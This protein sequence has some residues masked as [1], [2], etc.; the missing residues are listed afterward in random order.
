MG[1]KQERKKDK[2]D[3]NYDTLVALTK[4]AIADN[5]GL[6]DNLQGDV[7]L[8]PASLEIPGMGD[9]SELPSD[10]DRSDGGEDLGDI[11]AS[12]GASTSQGARNIIDPDSD[13]ESDYK[14]GEVPL[15]INP[16]RVTVFYRPPA[17]QHAEKII[18]DTVEAVNKLLTYESV[19]TEGHG[20][21]FMLCVYPRMTNPVTPILENILPGHREHVQKAI[22]STDQPKPCIVDQPSIPIDRRS[23]LLEKNYCVKY[24]DQKNPKVYKIDN[25]NPDFSPE[26]FQEFYCKY[27][28]F[29]KN[30]YNLVRRMLMEQSK[31]YRYNDVLDFAPLR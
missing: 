25:G 16:K 22:E 2:A 31:W 21:S 20:E 1:K 13:G 5:P 7:N 10:D 8:Q 11:I 18:R 28:G 29:P 24:L 6:G 9:K 14:D 23:A 17:Y 4:Q 30:D 3:T 26:K 15:P 12:G 27:Q 19:T